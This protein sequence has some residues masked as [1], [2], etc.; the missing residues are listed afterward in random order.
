MVT[1]TVTCR[2]LIFQNIRLVKKRERKSQDE[3]LE[4]D[5]DLKQDKDL[6]QDRPFAAKHISL[7]RRT[8]QSHAT[9]RSDASATAPMNRRPSVSAPNDVRDQRAAA[10]DLAPP[11]SNVQG[12][13]PDVQQVT[14]NQPILEALNVTGIADTRASGDEASGMIK[15]GELST[16]AVKW[17]TQLYMVIYIPGGDDIKMCACKLDTASSV[18]ILSWQTVN[19]LGVSME[20]YDGDM[21]VPLGDPVQPVGQVTLDWHVRGRSKT[22][23]TDF[24]VLDERSSRGFDALLSE[25]TIGDIGFYKLNETVWLVDSGEPSNG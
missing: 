3:D 12:L 2:E 19:R 4:Q 6:E 18:N 1:L 25:K 15:H 9:V 5:E 13:S 7:R 24:V 17:K 16:G 10:G 22:Y 14:P 23:T 11:A 8:L 20:P 21:V